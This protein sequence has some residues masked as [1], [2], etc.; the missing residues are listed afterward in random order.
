MDSLSLTPINLKEK[1]GLALINGTQFM[2]SLASETVVQAKNILHAAQKIFAFAFEIFGID[3]KYL[4]QE[5]IKMYASVQASV[6][7]SI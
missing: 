1:E 2:C 6:G 5:T 7:K 4:S 3:Y